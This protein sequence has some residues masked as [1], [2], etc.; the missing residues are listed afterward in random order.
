MSGVTSLTPIESVFTGRRDRL[1][2]VPADETAA[3][4]HHE[5]SC[6]DFITQVNGDRIRPPSYPVGS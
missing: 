1:H 3:L 2:H 4:T 5:E 6:S